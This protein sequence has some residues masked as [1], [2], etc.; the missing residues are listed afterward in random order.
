MRGN[1]IRS[2]GDQRLPHVVLNFTHG[3]TGFLCLSCAEASGL[4][5]WFGDPDHI[6]SRIPQGYNRFHDRSTT[7]SMLLRLILSIVSIAECKFLAY[8]INSGPA[9]RAIISW[10]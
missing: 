10:S 2:E 4:A 3:K 8:R 1:D 7:L 5:T 6:Y 9:G